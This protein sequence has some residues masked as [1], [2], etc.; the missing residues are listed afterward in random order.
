MMDLY[1]SSRRRSKSR[2]G[3][4][5]QSKDGSATDS[6][7]YT[8][9]GSPQVSSSP[10]AKKK[11]NPAISIVCESELECTILLIATRNFIE[12]TDYL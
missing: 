6:P 1:D 7:A 2:E 8:P 3:S 10:P 5:T 12:W 11:V 9:S 4:S